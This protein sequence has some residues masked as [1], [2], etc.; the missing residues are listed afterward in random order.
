M[1][2]LI[3]ISNEFK[4]AFNAS[5]WYLTRVCVISLLF[6]E[7]DKHKTEFIQALTTKGRALAIQIQQENE[8][9]GAEE[10]QETATVDASI[11]G[12]R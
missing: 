9:H 5:P 4:Y 12:K 10:P 3:S 2:R 8:K 11:T 1:G 6:S 7:T